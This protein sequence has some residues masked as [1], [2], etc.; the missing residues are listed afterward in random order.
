ME[1]MKEDI[2]YHSK[3]PI[4]KLKHSPVHSLVTFANPGILNL[5][6][7]E[8]FYIWFFLIINSNFHLKK[9]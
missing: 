1:K 8:I 3:K 9:T 6:I 5:Q 4:V 2:T 7:P